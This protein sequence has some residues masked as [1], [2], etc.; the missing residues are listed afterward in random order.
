MY[1]N[2]KLRRHFRCWRII[3]PC[4]RHA[5]EAQSIFRTLKSISFALFLPAVPMPSFPFT[6]RLH[7]VALEERRYPKDLADRLFATLVKD[8]SASNFR[9]GIE[10]ILPSRKDA[11]SSWYSFSFA[12]VL[13]YIKCEMSHHIKLRES[14]KL[15]NVGIQKYF[16]FY[17]IM[18]DSKSIKSNKLIFL[19]SVVSLVILAAV[20][21]LLIRLS[22]LVAFQV[23]LSLRI[24][25]KTY[26]SILPKDFAFQN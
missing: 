1:R 3:I 12:C 10:F 26:S 15:G 5:T 20:C 11:I 21:L 18:Q 8:G 6:P 25:V 13:L 19:Y 14:R 17:Q 4:T 16:A 23:K 7:A 9:V 2:E 24:I 22:I